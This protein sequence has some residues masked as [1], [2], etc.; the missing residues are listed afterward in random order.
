VIEMPFMGKLQSM[1]CTA[2]IV[3]MS[4]VFVGN[5]MPNRAPYLE[6]LVLLPKS[7]AEAGRSMRDTM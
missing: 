1:I 7:L 4:P 2:T 5:P 6:Y 3:N